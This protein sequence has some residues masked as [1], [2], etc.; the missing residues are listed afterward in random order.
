ME[1]E[2]KKVEEVSD[3]VKVVQPIETS[4]QKEQRLHRIRKTSLIVGIVLSGLVTAVVVGAGSYVGYIIASYNRVGNVKLDID[5]KA[6][7]EVVNVNEDLTAVTYN[8]GFGAYSQNYTFFL[9]TGYDDEGNETCG[10]WSKGRSKEEV[11]FNTNGS[12][13]TVKDLNPDFVMFQEV[14]TDST[15]SYHINQ[16]E[17]I[18]SEFSDYSHTFALNFHSKYLPYPLYDMHGSVNAGLTTISKYKINAAERKEYTIADDLSKLFD[19]DRCFS[20]QELATSNGKKLYIVNSHMSA[21]DE[22]GVIRATQLKE[23]NAFLKATKE[24]GAYVIVGGDFNHDLITYNPNYSY[25]DSA[26]RAFGMTK[27]TPDWVSFMFD[28]EG[29]HPFEEGFSIAAADNKPSCR[30]NDIEWDPKET[31]VCEVDGFIVSDNIEWSVETIET[32]NG[33]KGIDGFAFSDH[34]PVKLSFKL[35]A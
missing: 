21:Y 22:G 5:N 28:Q 12:I 14:D 18:T 33:N 32:K 10:H 31:F 3:E 25:D 7:K 4:K 2:N 11:L 24:E 34:Q 19:L 8:I 15:R 17:K 26:N 27:K 9:D 16:D 23:L 20:V 6:T 1:E 29:K 30:N 35:K 13:N